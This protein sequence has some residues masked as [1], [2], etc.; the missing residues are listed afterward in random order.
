MATPALWSGNLRLSLVLIPVRLVPAVSTEEAISF[1]Q[2]HEPSGKPIKYVKGVG[3]RTRGS[4]GIFSFPSKRGRPPHSPRGWPRKSIPN[5]SSR[6]LIQTSTSA[7]ALGRTVGGR[8][9]CRA[10]LKNEA[11]QMENLKSHLF[12]CV[13]RTDVGGPE[14][15]APETPSDL[16]KPDKPGTAVV[17]PPRPPI[18]CA[19]GVVRNGACECEPSFKPVKAAKTPGAACSIRSRRNRSSP[20]GRSLAPK[21]E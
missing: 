17:D 5:A 7:V 15:L 10:H 6:S 1:R 20:S 2:M 13:T 4:T 11:S 3:I 18:S 12:Q 8:E 19:N 9:P 21:A 16:Q 14:D